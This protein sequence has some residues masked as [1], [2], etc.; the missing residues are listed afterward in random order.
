M[1]LSPR[2][3]KDFHVHILAGVYSPNINPSVSLPFSFCRKY[4]PSRFY[5]NQPQR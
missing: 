3:V 4:P 5:P 2:L 1:P